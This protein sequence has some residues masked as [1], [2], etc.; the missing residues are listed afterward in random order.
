MNERQEKRRRLNARIDHI[1]AFARWMSQ[2]P[3]MWRDL[4]WHA[5]KKR[6]PRFQEVRDDHQGR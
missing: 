1:E 6:R 2:E 3:P 5:W 4:S